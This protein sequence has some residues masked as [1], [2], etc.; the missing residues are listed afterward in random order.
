[1]IDWLGGDGV[2]KG[3]WMM[4][5]NGECIP[6]EES[7]DEKGLVATATHLQRWNIGVASLI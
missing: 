3:G 6:N 7:G 2:A 4:V 5:P 1:M